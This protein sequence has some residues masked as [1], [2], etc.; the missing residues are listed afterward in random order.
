MGTITSSGVGSNIDI[1]SLVTRLVQAEG[2]AKSQQLQTQQATTQAKLSA[3]GQFRSALAQLQTAAGS[4]KDATIFRARSAT[5]GDADLMSVAA[6]ATAA[7]GTYA[8]EVVRLATGAKLASGPSAA[9]TTAVGTGTLTIT[10]RGGSFTVDVGSTNNTL[11]GIRDAI[12]SATGNSGVAATLVTANDGVRLVLTSTGVGAA[13]AIKVTQSGGDGG[14][15]A[16]AYDPSNGVNGLTQLQAAQDARVIV[17]GYTY[18][19]ASNSVTGALDGVTLTLKEASGAG[20]ATP[21]TIAT[22]TSKAQAVISAFV[23]A[24]NQAFSS[25]RSMGAYDATRQTGGVLLGDSMLR[26]FLGSLRTQV[27]SP[28]TGLAGNAYTALSDLGITTNLDGTL[29]AD[30]AKLSSALNGNPAAVQR[31]FTEEGGF[32]R[33]LDALLTDYVKTGGLIESR[34]GGLESTLKDIGRR[35]EQLERSLAA[36]ESRVRAQFTAMDTLVAQLRQ[37]G[38]NLVSQLNTIDANYY[39]NN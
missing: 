9:S 22:D 33:K 24:Y 18:D 5:V 16:I 13:S 35:Q 6:S 15:A 30:T 34:R 7:P 39:G 12:N 29:K 3:Y 27:G 37:T 1:E 32:A 20:V 2:A 11:A 23:A 4:L 21:V 14:L 19:S 36:F 17:D 10:T 25:L 31:L 28:L 26:G 38:D 8:V